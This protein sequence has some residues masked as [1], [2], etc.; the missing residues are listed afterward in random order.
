MF[1]TGWVYRTALLF[2]EGIQCSA[3][4]HADESDRPNANSFG[5]SK[6]FLNYAQNHASLMKP[7]LQIAV[8]HKDYG[9]A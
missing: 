5:F 3:S 1:R 7:S 8:G 6:K 9:E 4:N 2:G